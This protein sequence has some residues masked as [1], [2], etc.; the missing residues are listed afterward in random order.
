MMT[1][2]Q[3]EEGPVGAAYTWAAGLVALARKLISDGVEVDLSPIRPAVRELCD[4]IKTLPPEESS[5]WLAR[6]VDLQRELAALGHQMAVR[7]GPHEPGE[8]R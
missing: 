2:S 1:T 3:E 7:P 8:P 4:I 6:L 5:L